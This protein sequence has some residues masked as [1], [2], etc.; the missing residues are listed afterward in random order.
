MGNSDI[1]LARVLFLEMSSVN[2]TASSGPCELVAK[3]A[4]LLWLMPIFVVSSESLSLHEITVTG[5]T[6]IP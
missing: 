4:L 3:V 1:D 5:I 2:I 6:A